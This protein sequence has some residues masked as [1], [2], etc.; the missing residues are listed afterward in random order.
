MRIFD[1][2]ER[3]FVLR[4]FR[5]GDREFSGDLQ[6]L[7]ALDCQRLFQGGNVIRNS[8]AISIHATQ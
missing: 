3:R 6:T 1:R 8:V 7:R 2:P 5:A 4:R